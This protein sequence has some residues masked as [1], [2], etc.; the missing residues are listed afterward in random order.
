MDMTR[1]EMTREAMH[2]TREEIMNI[3]TVGHVD[4]G[5]S[6]VVGRLMADTGVLPE[7]KLEQIRENCRRNSKPFEYA[8]LLDALK[9]E[10]A[11]GITIDTA[12]CFFKTDKRH[13]IIIDAPGHIEFLKNMVTGASRAEAALLVIDAARGIEENTRRHGYFLSMLGI[14]QVAVLVNKMDLVDYR[15]EIFDEIRVAYADFLAKIGITP[16][17]FIPV[18]G[19]EGDNIASHS[20]HMPWYQGLNVLE[21]LDLFHTVAEPEDLPLRLPVQGV[22]KFTEGNDSRRIIAGTVEAGRVRAGDRVVL[23]PSGKRTTVK[24]LEYFNGP[25]PEQ[26]SAG[27]AAGLTMS[28]QIFIRRG[29]MVCREE[30]PGPRVGV[31]LKVNLFWLG[32][33]RL[34]QDKTYFLKCGTA[35]VEMRLAEVLRIVNASDLSYCLRQYVDKNEV[36]EC[37]LQLERP[38]AFDLAGECEAT[39]RFVIVDDYEIA[40]GGIITACLED[41]DFD[42]R[43]IRWSGDG[44]TAAERLRHSRHA[45]LV[46]W[47]TGLSGAGKTTIAQETERRLLEKG[48]RAYILDGDKLRRGLNRDLGFSEEERA[49]NIRRTAE[50]ADL[51]RDS[52]AIVLVTLISPFRASREQARRICGES[53]MEVWVRADL[54]TCAARDPKGLYAKANAGQIK[55][56]TGVSSPYEEPEQADLL[57]DTERSDEEECVETLLSAVLNRLQEGRA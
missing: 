23:M 49:E 46:V 26:F 16:A 35:K 48:F 31:R 52:G 25:T 13:Y 30:E 27:Q 45:G 3:V 33:Q 37:V 17:S 47:M 22:Y 8:F 20:P 28:Q 29:E 43:N 6:T 18:S 10:Q 12:R 5:K 41:Q 24:S 1:E 53:F 4:H 7:G 42:R 57:L 39:S 21:Q 32:K 2:T 55:D 51:F 11:Q 56:F 38:I 36:A 15:Q 40:G 50:V 19:M 14:R 34:S 54:A 44:V 9:N